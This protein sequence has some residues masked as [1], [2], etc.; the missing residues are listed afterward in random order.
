[1]ILGRLAHYRPYFAAD[2]AGID[3][4][5]NEQINSLFG[6]DATGMYAGQII[7]L[8]PGQ[9]DGALLEDYQDFAARCGQ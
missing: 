8:N 2:A 6:L 3:I 1:M 4:T 5:G 7:S 9:Y